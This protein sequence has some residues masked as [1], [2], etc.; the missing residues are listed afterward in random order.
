VLL[1]RYGRDN[2]EDVFLDVARGRGEAAREA[3]PREA[4]P[5]EAAPREAAQ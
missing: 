4:A 2:L 3:A 5:R 1:A